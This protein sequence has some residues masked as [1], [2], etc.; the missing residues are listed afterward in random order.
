VWVFFA[1][2][3]GGGDGAQWVNLNLFLMM[4]KSNYFKKQSSWSS[5]ITRSIQLE[6]CGSTECENMQYLL[7]ISSKVVLNILLN[8]LIKT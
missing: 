5:L 1:F 6:K 8:E 7:D 4:V 2:F 3:S